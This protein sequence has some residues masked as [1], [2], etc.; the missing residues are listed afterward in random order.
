[1]TTVC[2]FLLDV[3]MLEV[4]QGFRLGDGLINN[5]HLFVLQLRSGPILL[6]V[7]KVEHH[8]FFSKLL[9]LRLIDDVVG[10]KGL[11]ELIPEL[12]PCTDGA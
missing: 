2:F 7:H 11:L 1:M 3:V 6:A 12:L 5:G 4:S 8:V 9:V 10:E